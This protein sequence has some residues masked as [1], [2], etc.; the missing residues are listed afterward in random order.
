MS[1][2]TFEQLKEELLRDPRI[3]ESYNELQPEFELRRAI[4]DARLR[5]GVTQEDLARALGTTQ[6]AIS[7]MESGVFDPRLSS[8]RK[9][10]AALDLRIEI[11]AAGLKVTSLS[12]PKKT[13][14]KDAEARDSAA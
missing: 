7:R 6:S 8:L 1:N 10:A 3:E 11:T 9:L 13:N 5:K 2:F 12:I 14:I 4:I